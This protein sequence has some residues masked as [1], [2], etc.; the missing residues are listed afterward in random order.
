MILKVKTKLLISFSLFRN[1]K[2]HKKRMITIYFSILFSLFLGNII[3]YNLPQTLSMALMQGEL[4]YIEAVEDVYFLDAYSEA[5]E[6]VYPFY[7][8]YG[9]EFSVNLFDYKIN[10]TFED[11]FDNPFVE[12]NISERYIK[13]AGKQALF[14]EI[15]YILEKE[16]VSFEKLDEYLNIISLPM[17]IFIDG[18]EQ[19]FFI[20]GFKKGNKEIAIIPPFKDWGEYVFKEAGCLMVSDPYFA[21][22]KYIKKTYVIEKEKT[23]GL[24]L[25]L[26]QLLICQKEIC[27]IQEAESNLFHPQQRLMLEGEYV[28]IPINPFVSGLSYDGEA[29]Y[30]KNIKINNKDLVIEFEINNSFTTKEIGI[31]SSLAKELSLG[32]GDKITLSGTKQEKEYKIAQIINKEE[33]KIYQSSNWIVVEGMD[34]SITNPNE[35]L[36]NTIYLLDAKE[37]TILGK[38]LKNTHTIIKKEILKLTKYIKIGIVSFIFIS[39][40]LNVIY[41]FLLN[42]LDL[43]EQEIKLKLLQNLG[44]S[45]K[46]IKGY[47]YKAR[48]YGLLYAFP[49][50]FLA[51][52]A[53]K[54]VFERIIDNK[55][56]N[57]ITKIIPFMN[58]FLSFLMILI[59]TILISSITFKNEKVKKH[60]F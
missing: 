49:M 4:D 26:K 36:A 25:N 14:E 18:I 47:I 3:I 13:L 53:L 12:V 23:K 28:F 15:S 10:L 46:E 5:N 48:I 30:L 55:I 51:T 6:D 35:Y 38:P 43:K 11:F 29:F 41:L 50:A 54:V 1:N 34:I 32:L 31:S 17:R 7:Q 9:Y 45:N 44:Y 19:V 24:P 37:K 59:L 42:L 58:I 20:N 21:S 39:L 52:I 60:H 2:K 22:D 33:L 56:I 27:I 8:N 16:F 57:S 40:S